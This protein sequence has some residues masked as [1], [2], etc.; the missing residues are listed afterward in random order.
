MRHA[1][2]SDNVKERALRGLEGYTSQ[3]RQESI[4]EV[5]TWQFLHLTNAQFSIQA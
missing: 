5:A 4:E 2:P 3:K 1:G